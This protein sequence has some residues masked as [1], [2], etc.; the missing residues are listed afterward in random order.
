MVEFDEVRHGL[1][2]LEGDRG[3]ADVTGERQIERSG[4]FAMAVPI[5]LPRAGVAFVVQ[6]GSCEKSEL[7]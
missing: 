5:L 4:G 3:Q 2:W 7:E 1:T 6:E